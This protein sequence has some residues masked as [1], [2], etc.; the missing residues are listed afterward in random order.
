M[1]AL[2][3]VAQTDTAVP[4]SAEF[5]RASGGAIDVMTKGPSRIS[6][7]FSLTHSTGLFGGARYEGSLGGTIVPDRLWFFS[8]A[9]VLPRTRFS[10][11]DMTP[12]NVKADA[13]PVDWANVTASFNHL[14]QPVFAPAT[15]PS[16]F[17]SL[18]STSMLSDRMML[19][20]SLS[21]THR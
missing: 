4:V 16:S 2:A 14:A 15:L 8:A 7:T 10:T 20:F 6:G 3:A 9:S 17:L 21:Q 11:S 1:F 13:Q 19:N 12:V 18:H 5:G